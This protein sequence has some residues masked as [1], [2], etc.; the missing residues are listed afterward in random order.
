MA[1]SASNDEERA[2]AA[3]FVAEVEKK[4]KSLQKANRKLA[5]D[6]TAWVNASMAKHEEASA[7]PGDRGSKQEDD[8]V[9]L[10]VEAGT[11]VAGSFDGYEESKGN[12]S[13]GSAG[14]WFGSWLR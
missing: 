6:V 14:S 11:D 13:G 3:R 12:K 4:S 7:A 1:R 5:R 8:D 2:Q 9:A 10:P